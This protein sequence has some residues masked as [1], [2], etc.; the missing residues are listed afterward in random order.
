MID[1]H[2]LVQISLE[3]LNRL[4]KLSGMPQTS[5]NVVFIDALDCE[6][7]PYSEVKKDLNQELMFIGHKGLLDCVEYLRETQNFID[8]MWES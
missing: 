3:K 2:T 6:S 4:G 1:S 8:R 7:L 5:K